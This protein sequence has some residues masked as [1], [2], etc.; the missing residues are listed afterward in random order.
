MQLYKKAYYL[1]KECKTHWLLL[2]QKHQEVIKNEA[3]PKTW[4]SLQRQ[5]KSLK[6]LS[7]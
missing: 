5:N 1:L 6:L 2:A 7:K 4:E 3:F